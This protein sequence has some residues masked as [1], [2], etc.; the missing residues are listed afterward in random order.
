MSDS[1]NSEECISPLKPCAWCGKNSDFVCS[2]CSWLTVCSQE[3][4]ARSWPQH[5]KVCRKI[6]RN[7]LVSNPSIAD[8][9][10]LFSLD[11]PSFRASRVGLR[12][13]SNEKPDYFLVLAAPVRK[14][15]LGF[16]DVKSLCRMEQVMNNIYSLMAWIEALKGLE[17]KAL[18]EWPVVSD[19]GES[20]DFASLRWSLTRG[21]RLDPSRLIIIVPSFPS[22]T[23]SIHRGHQFEWLCRQNQGCMAAMLIE[24]GYIAPNTLIR[25]KEE[26]PSKFDVKEYPLSLLDIASERGSRKAVS[27]LLR[28]KQVDIHQRNE[29]GWTA[30]HNASYL[31]R[32]GTVRVL[33]EEGADLN[34]L[35]QN[36]FHPLYLSV[37]SKHL[38]TVTAILEGGCNVNRRTKQGVTALMYACE[39][40]LVPIM[41][42][43]LDAGAKTEMSSVSIGAYPLHLTTYNS[44]CLGAMQ[45]LVDRRVDLNVR[46]AEGD[47]ALMLAADRNLVDHVKVLLQGGANPNMSTYGG[48]TA[49]S[50]AS[51]QGLLS[52]VQ[53]LLKGGAEVN[54]LATDFDGKYSM[55]FP[56]YNAAGKGHIAVAKTLIAAGA[57]V[58]MTNSEGS[59]SLMLACQKGHVQLVKVLITASA[60]VNLVMTSSNCGLRSTALTLTIETD[61]IDDD[62]HRL[63]VVTTLIA[64]GADVNVRSF[65]SDPLLILAI[66][67]GFFEIVQ[68]LC[69]G[70]ADP[71]QKDEEGLAAAALAQRLNQNRVYRF[72][73]A[74]SRKRLRA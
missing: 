3:C 52:V 65:D 38:P 2:S 11:N 40:G 28:T 69:K 5:Q 46:D 45:L 17:S 73:Q 1:V 62:D 56:L 24:C 63:D 20:R 9:R 21:V 39:H 15:L 6:R 18:S 54:M 58:D 32:A 53:E 10:P 31:C 50:D 16:L 35:S 14:H 60:N 70:G 44:S 51:G 72:L 29:D 23:T 36:G 41:G 55:E 30:I 48:S 61:K 4:A 19:E 26:R 7:P 22:S 25:S 43:L 59:T 37:Q 49:L 42:A 47:T 12:C 71:L 64:A 34:A 57:D 74:H 27:A 13:K 67:R 66:R 33:I 68:A 8:G